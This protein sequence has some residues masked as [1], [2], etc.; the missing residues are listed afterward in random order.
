MGYEIVPAAPSDKAVVRTSKALPLEKLKISEHRRWMREKLLDGIAFAPSTD[1]ALLLHK[2]ICKFTQLPDEEQELDD[3]IIGVIFEL[4]REK[5][6]AL[7]KKGG[8]AEK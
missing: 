7:I 4:L 6:L 5:G 2:D 8:G 3:S 1:D